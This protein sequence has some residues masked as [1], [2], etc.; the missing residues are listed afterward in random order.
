M[1]MT[2][3][4]FSKTG[5]ITKPYALLSFSNLLKFIENPSYSFIDSRKKITKKMTKICNVTNYYE[6]GYQLSKNCLEFSVL[7]DEIKQLKKEEEIKEG[8]EQ[9]Y[10]IGIFLNMINKIRNNL[11]L[12]NKIDI[13]SLDIPQIDDGSLLLL[14][15]NEYNIK[16]IN[17]EIYK[18]KKKWIIFNHYKKSYF[19]N[20]YVNLDKTDISRIKLLNDIINTKKV[21]SNYYSRRKFYGNINE[22]LYVKCSI[23]NPLLITLQVSSIKLQCDFIPETKDDNESEIKINEEKAK[24][25]IGNK[26]NLILNEEQCNLSPMEERQILLNVSSSISGKIIIKG[27][28]FVLFKDSQIIHP[29]YQKRKNKLYQYRQKSYSTDNIK[30]NK[31]K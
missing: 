24:N 30:R 2:G 6:G 23:K 14:E 26:D 7:Y 12:K 15:E 1:V 13:T 10:Y 4:Y 16:K 27:L 21:I 8:D 22:K 11:E 17:S 9:S 3:K 19:S 18:D 29:F 28:S 20:P 25:E 5:Q 31:R